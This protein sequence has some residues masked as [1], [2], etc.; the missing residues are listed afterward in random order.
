MARRLGVGK[1]AWIEVL[2]KRGFVDARSP[3]CW[4]K[5]G[6]DPDGV[7]AVRIGRVLH[8]EGADTSRCGDAQVSIARPG[9]LSGFPRQSITRPAG[10]SIHEIQLGGQRDDGK[11]RE[12]PTRRSAY[13]ARRDNRKICGPVQANSSTAKHGSTGSWTGSQSQK[14]RRCRRSHDVLGSMASDFDFQAKAR[15]ERFLSALA[16]S[17]IWCLAPARWRGGAVARWRGG[18]V[19]R[20]RGGAG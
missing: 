14:I 1:R 20:W 8:L 4:Q 9:V 3:D 12:L 5:P 6:G 17:A 13:R 16:S 18:A 7:Q 11:R 15:I 10:W 2:S 19:A